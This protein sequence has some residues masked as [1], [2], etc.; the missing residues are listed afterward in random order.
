MYKCDEHF[1][2]RLK[3]LN[4]RLHTW[5]SH[6]NELCFHGS[7][8]YRLLCNSKVNAWKNLLFSCTASR[9]E[10]SDGWLTVSLG[11][12]RFN[13]CIDNN[14][15]WT[16]RHRRFPTTLMWQN[17]NCKHYY[18]YVTCLADCLL[19]VSSTPYRL[20]CLCL[21]VSFKMLFVSAL[22]SVCSQW[23]TGNLGAEGCQ[24]SFITTNWHSALHD[25]HF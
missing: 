2:V 19:A 16:K 4:S 1:L 11:K 5:V 21:L 24:I 3:K 22:C 15:R 12:L 23:C 10:S 14:R 6:Y 8:P 9:L 25:R 18:K 7:A 17:L 13:R 20:N